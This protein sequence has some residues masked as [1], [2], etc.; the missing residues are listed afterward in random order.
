VENLPFVEGTDRIF[1]NTAS[2]PLDAID[3]Q[4]GPDQGAG[5]DVIP[6]PVARAVMGRLSWQRSL[7]EVDAKSLTQGAESHEGPILQALAIE[8]ANGGDVASLR[9]RIRALVKE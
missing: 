1:L 4:Y 7:D 5:A 8:R 6:L 3:A 9:E 2:L